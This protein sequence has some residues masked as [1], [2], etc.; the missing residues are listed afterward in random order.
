VAEFPTEEDMERVIRRLD[1]SD[2]LG[3]RVMV[4]QVSWVVM[5]VSHYLFEGAG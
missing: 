4:K 3:R 1:D 2:F 5:V